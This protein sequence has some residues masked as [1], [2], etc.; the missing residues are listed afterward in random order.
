MSDGD[1]DALLAS[2]GLRPAAGEYTLPSLLHDAIRTVQRERG[3][4]AAR[5]QLERVRG[6]RTD[7]AL[8]ADSALDRQIRLVLEVM[9]DAMVPQALEATQARLRVLSAAMDSATGTSPELAEW[10][11]RAAAQLDAAAQAQAEGNAPLAL[12]R[13]VAAAE[14]AA[15]LRR[16][17]LAGRRVHSLPELFVQA[18][19]RIDSVAGPRAAELLAE[20]ARLTA[21]ARAA[22]AKTDRRAAHRA[23]SAQRAEEIRLTVGTLGPDVA[24]AV[25]ADVER[26]LAALK[27]ALGSNARLQRMHRAAHDLQVRSARELEKG[28]PESALDL[29]SHAASLTNALMFI[30]TLR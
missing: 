12:A 22:V 21:A 26:A 9:G 24:A 28:Q 17:L 7:A 4:D 11:A 16:E 10:R 27:P 13:T 2:A 19:S 29:G 5:L 25:V 15:R 18:R 23:L 1:V 3:T 14:A 20:H 6:I 30:L 8:A